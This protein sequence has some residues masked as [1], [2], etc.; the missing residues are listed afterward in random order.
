M[1]LMNCVFDPFLDKFAILF[2]D[3]I[4]VYS[5]TREKY[6]RA[7]LHHFAD[8]EGTLFVYQVS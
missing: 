1:D 3:D 2:I 4:L 8:V 7:F 6:E 5:P